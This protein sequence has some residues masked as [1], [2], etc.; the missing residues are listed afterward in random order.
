[1]SQ[2]NL[3]EVL[4]C[5]ALPSLPAV[6]VRLLEL[7]GDP[8]V[9]MSDI[10]QLV[11]QDQAL[12][13]KVLKTVNSSFYG[14]SNPCGSIERAMGYLGLNTVKSLVLGFSLVET[15]K[16]AGESGFDLESH[17][18]RAII[19]ATGARLMA[20]SVGTVDPEEAF[21]SALFQDLGM[22]ASFA[23]MSVSYS[24]VVDGVVHPELIGVEREN[25]EFD[26]SLVG[27]ELAKKWKLPEEICE[28]IRCHHA[29]E[30]TT[31]KFEALSRVVALGAILCDSMNLET[32]KSSMSKLKRLS[33]EWY[34]DRA[35]D[36]SELIDEVGETSRTL[37]KMFEQEIG[38]IADAATLM[39]EAQE[40]GIEH[41][42]TV[43]READKMA[44]EALIDG[45][46]QIAN[47]KRFDAELERVYNDFR[48]SGTEF[49]VIFFDADKFKSVNDTYGHAAGDAVLVELAKR[50][51]E[52]VSSRGVVCRYGGEEFTV[53]VQDA[54]LDENAQLGEEI[55]KIVE[56]TPF[57]LS[58]VE[59]VPDEL[60]VTVSVGVSSTNAG[61]HSRLASADQIV[62]E[63][64]ECVYVAK[65]NGRNMVHV[66]SQVVPKSAQSGNNDEAQITTEQQS[67]T[68]F[69]TSNKSNSPKSTVPENSPSAPA[70]AQPVIPK[71][72]KAWGAGRVL[73]VE[74]D[75]LAA[76]L[77]ISL[78]KRRSKL[79]IVWVKSGTKAC[80]MMES[81]DFVNE[82]RLSLIMCDYMLP[83]CNGHEVL[84]V[85]KATESM[86]DVPFI[87]LTGNTDQDMKDESERLGVSLFIRKDEFC[88]DVNKWLEQLMVASKAAA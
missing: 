55:R 12:A 22:L 82:N 58:K 45:L 79:E 40:R 70:A 48:S 31:T 67:A 30:L 49:G 34:H 7:T 15:T 61:V 41:Q 87:M 10:A 18:R 24:S 71:P 33:K 36:V 11:Q 64:D 19:G 85:A 2:M 35:P 29:P 42:L 52:A 57:D 16:D 59:G 44:H 21:T 80:V 38:E 88:A 50:C 54:T 75:P 6:A 25:F 8:D 47:R 77:L 39:S 60:K 43:Q 76:T 5:S 69:S 84:K 62:Q 17:W 37:A 32:S 74:D 20:R 46:T 73:L 4:N 66:H 68:Q 81:G 78:I 65:K 83:G 53:I 63:A 14:L 13:A 23:A 26:H 27:S 56:A 3:Q 28:G 51:S 1:V 72:K 86:V 9:S